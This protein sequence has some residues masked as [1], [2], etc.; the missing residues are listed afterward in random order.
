MIKRTL[1]YALLVLL[2]CGIAG[3]AI[4]NQSE[5]AKAAAAAHKAKFTTTKSFTGKAPVA[6]AASK[7]AT[8]VPM[9]TVSN[10]SAEMISNAERVNRLMPEL[11][12]ALARGD[13]QAA[14]ALKSE[15]DALNGASSAP[16]NGHH[17]DTPGHNCADPLIVSLP[18]ALPYTD[19]AQTTCGRGNDITTGC[20]GSYFGAEDIIYRIDVTAPTSCTFTA[21]CAAGDWPGMALSTTCTFATCVFS[22][23]ASGGTITSGPQ[24]LA[25][26]TYWLVI[27]DWPSPACIASFT[28]TITAPPPPPANDLC[29]NAIPVAIPSATAGTTVNASMGDASVFCDGYTSQTAP[30]VWYTMIG[31]G[32]FD[33]VDL[34]TG[35]AFDTR[36]DVYTG[37]CNNL[38]CL[39][40]NDDACS[41]QSRVVFC[42]SMGVQYYILVTAYSTYTGP[43]TLSVRQ[44]V[45]CSVGRCC[46]GP[47]PLN[48]SC[49]NNTEAACTA[50]GGSWLA[51][52]TC[53]LSPC[54][55]PCIVTC[56]TGG[57]PE[58]EPD[59]ADEYVDATNGGCNSTPNVFQTIT[60][61]QTICGKSGTYLYTGLNYRDTDWFEVVVPQDTNL[62]W[63]ARAEFPV[64]LFILNGGCPAATV[65]AS[66]TADSCVTTSI[67]ATVA[68]G[69]YVVWIGP[70]IFAGITC[71][72]DY[73]ATL[74]ATPPPQGR[75][76]YGP[77]QAPLCAMTTA[78]V[79]ATLGGQWDVSLTC[80]TPCP[81]RP[82][83]DDCIN[84]T[85]VPLT[86]GTPITFTGDNT[87]ATHDCSLL[88]LG[89][90]EVWH[91]ITTTECTMLTV[92]YC[93]M[94]PSWGD[95]YI[96]IA[97]GCPCGSLIYSTW[98]Q[99]ECANGQVTE[100]YNLLPA[101]TYYIP[102]LTE[103]AY[104][105]VGPYTL[106]VSAEACPPPPANDLCA[107]AIPIV[108]P[109]VYN[110]DNTGAGTDFTPTDPYPCDAGYNDIWYCLTA[111]SSCSV[112]VNT[113][114]STIDTRLYV[115]NGCSCP[116]GSVVGCN[117][118]FCGLQSQVGFIAIAGES[119]L[120]RV[121]SYGSTTQGAGTLTLTTCAPCPDVT[122]LTVLLSP[123]NSHVWLHFTAP[124][125]GD[126]DIYSTQNKN[127]DGDPR[128]GDPDFTLAAT[129]N[130]A[131]AGD[132]VNWTDPV[133]PQPFAPDNYLNYVVIN[134]E[135]TPPVLGR[136]CYGDPNAP[137]CA[138]NT[139]SQCA[140]L[141][142]TW[143][144]GL[145]C[146][147]DPC[148]G[149]APANDVCSGAVEIF[150]GTPI[151][152]SSANATTDATGW[153]C[154][155]LPGFDMWYV[156]NCTTNG[157]ADATTCNANGDP[158]FD[159][160]IGVYSDC[161]YTSVACNDDDP[162]G[163]TYYNYMSRATWTT[164]SGTTYY[165]RVAGYNGGS[166]TYEVS[167]IQN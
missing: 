97:N 137:D 157:T 117:D 49:A 145:T 85:P 94:D 26:G 156:Y 126:Y 148:P 131:L 84:V 31:T 104:N 116:P 125:A 106:T 124:T 7:N 74:S 77:G 69:T 37:D 140:A 134:R 9:G 46:Y 101:G 83:N 161:N 151:V 72:A 110:F 4:A 149:P 96:V 19:A 59:C 88:T 141:N 28:L 10:N 79:C 82:N 50:L 122:D 8:V 152:A 13:E 54:P 53:E 136:C 108:A 144:V 123:D 64:L 36:L 165:I 52:T 129:G 17:L 48:P 135:C 1:W 100:H 5:D 133:I 66:G 98:N 3:M 162:L 55:I 61:G 159:T 118:D 16:R 11:K 68:A 24:S 154:G 103:A 114:G 128:G 58:G 34:C 62:T 40:G 60:I 160:V 155:Y 132:V 91:A 143:T 112:Y 138:D 111:Q 109:G 25:V 166:G 30:G 73:W 105:A 87:G 20:L 22:V 51:G 142:G 130:A 76:C 95:M 127:N 121:A 75:C 45:D 81:L 147:L 158:T 42:A 65:Y 107:N 119:Y 47:D 18:A 80:D 12:A 92:S 78:G 70:S 29:A 41:V 38:V 86:I 23:T 27:D 93:D 102:V 33:T 35:T 21:A 39:V 63:T 139:S 15:I 71:G 113:C 43:F 164:V 163:C 67:T 14:Q 89:E 167:V 115:Y 2:C 32:T 150:A 57:V 99:T 153:T 6:P 44:G 146:A 90:G 56:P 120:I